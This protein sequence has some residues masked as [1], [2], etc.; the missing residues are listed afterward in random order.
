[1]TCLRPHS[2]S[3]R[4]ESPGPDQH[5]ECFD[6]AATGAVGV[7]LGPS[8]VGWEEDE[9]CLC[10]LLSPIGIPVQPG[11]LS[12]VLTGTCSAAVTSCPLPSIPEWFLAFVH[13]QKKKKKIISV[14]QHLSQIAD[15]SLSS[16][17][18]G[19][20]NPESGDLSPLKRPPAI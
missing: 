15:C 6:M 14:Y 7:P 10:P 20:A 16:R 19:T 13:Q 5:K 9:F 4:T 8:G 2:E 1:M 18:L 3:A 11:E 12:V 17:A